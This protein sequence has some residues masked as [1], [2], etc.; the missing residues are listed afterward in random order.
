[1]NKLKIGIVDYG[2]G[3]QSSI[4]NCLKSIGFKTLIS[5]EIEILE[6][7]QILLLPGVGAFEPSMTLLKRKKLDK[8][9]IEKGESEK[10]I[11]GI[12]LGMQLLATKSNENGIHSGL[13]LIPGTVEQLSK[14][15]KFHIGWNS[16]KVLKKN[17]FYESKDKYFYF[18]HSYAF[19]TLKDYS[20]C[21]TKFDEIEFNSVIKKNKM[22]GVQFH[23]EKSQEEGKKFLFD[24][25]H[26]LA[27]A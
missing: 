25:I 26:G 14:N 3:N 9:I 15:N 6:E 8:Y 18:N 16:V 23:P 19:K 13:N 11:I 22:V 2:I 27:N 5:N 21:S 20:I 24:L 12:C 17:N 4:Q 7:S 1:M 10:P